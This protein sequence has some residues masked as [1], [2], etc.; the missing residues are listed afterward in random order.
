MTTETWPVGGRAE[1]T[2]GT[3]WKAAGNIN[4]NGNELSDYIIDQSTNTTYLKGRFLGKVCLFS[5][6]ILI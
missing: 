3:E 5:I 1:L 2:C 6:T 4:N